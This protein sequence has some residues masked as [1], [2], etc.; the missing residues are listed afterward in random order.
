LVV[1]V[2]VACDR[3]FD[4]H[5]VR[6][7]IARAVPEPGVE[8]EVDLGQVGP[9]EIVDR[10]RVRAGR[11]DRWEVLIPLGSPSLPK[12]TEAEIDCLCYLFYTRA[13]APNLI[14]ACPNDQLGGGG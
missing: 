2:F 1:L 10:D 6:L 14:P 3:P 8:I 5:P 12:D 7:A 11:L 9:R 4:D 13:N